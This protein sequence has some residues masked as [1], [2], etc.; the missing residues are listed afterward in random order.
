MAKRHQLTLKDANT[1]PPS[2]KVHVLEKFHN[3]P[4]NVTAQNVLSLYNIALRAASKFSYG[5]RYT[6]TQPESKKLNLDNIDRGVE[7]PKVNTH[8]GL[9]KHSLYIV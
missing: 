3:Q 6:D 1:N 7:I 9:T 5:N 8:L 2:T 4:A